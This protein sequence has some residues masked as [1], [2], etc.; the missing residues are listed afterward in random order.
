MA[1]PEMHEAFGAFAQEA[2]T[3]GVFVGRY[4]I[5]PD[6]IHLFAAFADRA[7][8][9]SDWMKALKRTLAKRLGTL[10]VRGTCWQKGFFDHVIRSAESYSQ[11]WLYVRENPVRACLVEAPEDWSYQGEIHHLTV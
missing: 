11:K 2:S 3:R 6:H 4:V 7:P 10:G 8:G 1:N 9:V 5:M